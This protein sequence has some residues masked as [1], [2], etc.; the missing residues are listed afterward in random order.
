MKNN[1]LTVQ[2]SINI[3]LYKSLIKKKQKT[4]QLVY[5]VFF[6]M[7]LTEISCMTA[8]TC[9]GNGSDSLKL[10]L[11]KSGFAYFASSGV[12]HGSENH[13]MVRNL[14]YQ[15]LFIRVVLIYH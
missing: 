2:L 10:D 13:E 5:S 14:I 1:N 12:R 9:H 8:Q 6:L 15:V 7:N 11:V 3:F 4:Q